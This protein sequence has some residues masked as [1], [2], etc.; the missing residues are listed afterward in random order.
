MA[1]GLVDV[2]SVGCHLTWTNGK[3]WSKL[4]RVMVNDAWIQ[5]GLVASTHFM[6]RW[7]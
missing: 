5:A 6:P 1:L 2:N 4:Y 7:E 3:V